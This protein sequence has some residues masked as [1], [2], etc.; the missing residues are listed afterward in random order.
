MSKKMDEAVEE[1]MSL[2]DDLGGSEHMSK[3]QYMEFCSEI[4]E[5]CRA[6]REATQEELGR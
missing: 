5:R 3:E 4:E 1:V 6:N 2:V